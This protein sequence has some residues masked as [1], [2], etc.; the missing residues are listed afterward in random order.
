ME[1]AE[2]GPRALVEAVQGSVGGFESF[3]EQAVAH[4]LREKGWTVVPQIGVS[5]FRIDLGVV[6]PDHPGNY[7]VGVECD[8]ASYHSAATARDRDKVRARILGALGWS[9]VRI[10]ST[11]WWVDPVGAMDRLDAK[12]RRELEDRRTDETQ[13]QVFAPNACL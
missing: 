6:H 10:W 11:D 13:T 7:L 3:F 2:R 9:L 8:G 4:G 1:F 5:R 12:I